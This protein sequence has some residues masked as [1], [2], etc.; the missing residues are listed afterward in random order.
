MERRSAVQFQYD[1]GM[2]WINPINKRNIYRRRH[3]LFGTK[4]WLHPLSQS[5]GFIPHESLQTGKCY[6][7]DLMGA[8]Q[9]LLAN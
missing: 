3:A 6:L 5:K 1:T 8:Q 2:A 7:G 9:L 4:G